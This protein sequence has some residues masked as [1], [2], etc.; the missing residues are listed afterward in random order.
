M[1][2]IPTI[3]TKQTTNVHL[4]QIIEHKKY[5]LTYIWHWKSRGGVKKS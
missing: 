4:P 2:N 5:A 1:V 3:S